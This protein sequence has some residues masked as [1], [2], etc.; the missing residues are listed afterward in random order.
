MFARLRSLFRDELGA[1]VIEYA[2]LGS[3]IAV[4][5]LFGIS[6]LGANVGA[7]LNT[8]GATISAVSPPSTQ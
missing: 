3:L 8:S 1:S 7:Q 4:I 5:C 6:V 2:L